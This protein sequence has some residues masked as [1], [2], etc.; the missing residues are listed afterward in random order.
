MPKSCLTVFGGGLLYQPDLSG[1]TG[2]NLSKTAVAVNTVHKMQKFKVSD[3]SY[4]NAVIDTIVTV[5]LCM[6]QVTI[7]INK[8]T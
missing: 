3:S 7:L 6:A 4:C 2:L 5:L 1:R 8:S